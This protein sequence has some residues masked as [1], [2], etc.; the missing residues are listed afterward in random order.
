M[1]LRE[2]VKMPPL[3]MVWAVGDSRRLDLACPRR[4]GRL[5]ADPNHTPIRKKAVLP[6]GA[7]LCLDVTELEAGTAV[8]GVGAKGLRSTLFAFL[9][10]L[11][12]AQCTDRGW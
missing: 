8:A 9:T 4:D 11:T 5:D 6:E 12:P 2:R 10:G 7:I 3:A 1:G